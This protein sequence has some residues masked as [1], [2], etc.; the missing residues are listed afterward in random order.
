MQADEQ[1]NVIALSWDIADVSDVAGFDIYKGASGAISTTSNDDLVASIT[2]TSYNDFNVIAGAEYCY[3]IVTYDAAGNQSDPTAETCVN[4]DTTVPD[5]SEVAFSSATYNVDESAGSIAI[6]VSRTG[7]VSAAASVD[8]SAVAGTATAGIDFAETTGTLNWAVND[9]ND[10]TFTI[11]LTENAAVESPETV[12]LALT[13]PSLS[14]RLGAINESVLTINDAPQVAC[15]DLSPTTINVDT[16]LSNPC[17][18]VN[19]NVFVRDAATLTID[20]G[21]RLVFAAGNSL[22]VEADGILNATGTAEAPIVFTGQ[23]AANGYWDGIEIVSIATSRLVHTVVEY[24]GNNISAPESG[25]YVTGN[26]RAIIT[27]SVVRNN[28][29]YGIRASSNARLTSFSNNVITLNENA[30]VFMTPNQ[31]FTIDSSTTYTGNVAQNGESR[32]YIL[33]SGGGVTLNQTWNTLDVH[34]LINLSSMNVGAELTL[35]PGAKL[36]F[37]SNSRLNFEGGGTLK[38][39]GTQAEPIIFTGEQASPGYW[40][41]IEFTNNNN[42][43]VMDHV[44]VEYGGGANIDRAANVGVRGVGAQRGRLTISNSLLQHSAKYGFEFDNDID[45]TMSNVVSTN[46]LRPG[47]IG[48]NDLGL[49][50]TASIYSGNTD[51]RIFVRADSIN[52]TQTMQLL[53]VPYYSTSGSPT[54]VDAA[55]T[56]EPSVELQFFSGGGFT[57]RSSGTLIIDG[58]PEEKILLTGAQKTKGYWKGVEFRGSQSPNLINH[59]IIEYGGNPTN[60]T[61]GLISFYGSQPINISNGTVSNTILRHSSTNGLWIDENTT[62]SFDNNNTFEDIDGLNVFLD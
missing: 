43:N 17:Y 24:A 28:A 34:Y 49:L 51:D 58:T 6:T 39:I 42:D 57:V 55:L 62:G 56:I 52:R 54:L 50:D 15:V 2:A 21:V 26:G 25:V 11:Q 27:D 37:V 10:K 4:V 32:D 47:E 38:A 48:F 18:N 31:V 1:S 33:L 12:L 29:G 14:T 23:I 13:N 61:E 30:P 45:L 35:L 5:L 16:T 41:G 3:V 53:D 59:A 36:V 46:N 9:N 60:S 7:D 20:P 40:K 8:Y 19:T 44:I 22:D